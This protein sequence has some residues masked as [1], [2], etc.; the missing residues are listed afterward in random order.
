MPA[1]GKKQLIFWVGRNT[2]FR[3]SGRA[4][5]WKDCQTRR[6]ATCR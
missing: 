1:D 3:V 4:D 2:A 5:T 6:R